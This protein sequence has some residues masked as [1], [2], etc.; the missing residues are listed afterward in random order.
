MKK[1]LEFIKKL[2]LQVYYS[3]LIIKEEELTN[4][5]LINKLKAN[6][7]GQA[8]DCWIIYNLKETNKGDYISD[9]EIFRSKTIN[10]QYNLIMDDKLLFNT[11]FGNYVKVPKIFAYIDH[12]FM[13]DLDGNFLKTDDILALTRKEKVLII[14]PINGGGGNNVHIL[15]DEE[16]SIDKNKTSGKIKCLCLDN[17]N[18][19]QNELRNFLENLNNFIITEFIKQHPYINQIFSETANSIRIITLRNPKND[20]LTIPVAVHRIGRLASF[21]VDNFGKGGLSVEIDLDTGVLGK[22]ASRLNYKNSAPVY[23]SRH[24]DTN[25]LITGVKIP[26]WQELKKTLISTSAKFPFIP[27]FAWDIIITKDGFTVM[28]IN[29]SSGAKVYQ[30]FG[31]KK[32][33][34]IGDF[35]RHHGIFK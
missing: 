5:S 8:G 7:Q 34:L 33:S 19:D 20:K 1:F 24:P 4:V 25:K 10:R 11:V 15:R 6:F 31:G 26:Y 14:K 17:L 12:G 28:E 35:Y 16:H 18:I 21:P 13:R 9:H 27:F 23:M 30:V 32:N 2:L 29:K 22:A 3:Y